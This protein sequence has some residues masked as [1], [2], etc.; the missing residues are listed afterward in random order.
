VIDDEKGIDE[1]RDDLNDE[2]ERRGLRPEEEME[3]KQRRQDG[4]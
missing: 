1:R 3:R 4:D 2:I